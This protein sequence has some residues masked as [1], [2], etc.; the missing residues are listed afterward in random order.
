ML[1]TFSCDLL[2][3]LVK[4]KKSVGIS[5]GIDWRECSLIL[6]IHKYGMSFHLLKF[7]LLMFYFCKN[8][9]NILLTMQKLYVGELCSSDY[10]VGELCSTDY[11]CFL[12][13]VYCGCKNCLFIFI[14]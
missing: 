4:I 3:N 5:I 1:P 11:F 8:F 13:I 10:Y 2:S 6:P 12:H 7:F 14:F 9:N